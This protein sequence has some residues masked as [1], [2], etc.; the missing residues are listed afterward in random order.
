MSTFQ[1][2]I[3][4]KA[5][6]SHRPFYSDYVRHCLRFYTRNLRLS[7]FKSDIDKSNWYACKV[8][9]SSYDYSSQDILF[10]VYSGYDTLADNVYETA[11]KH[12]INQSIIWDLMKEV[13]RKIA[14]ARG[15]L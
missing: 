15:L 6:Q 2:T 10:A 9:L 1:N 5:P 14:K 11:K 13:E 7:Q 12:G 4:A 3:G 8:V